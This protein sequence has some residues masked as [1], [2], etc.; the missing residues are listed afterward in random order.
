[1]KKITANS[2]SYAAKKRNR[3]EV[4]YIIIHYTGNTGD[5]AIDNGRFFKRQTDREAG[6]HFFIDREGVIVKSVA[7]NRSAWAVGGKKLNAGGK[8]HGIITNANSVS[9]ELCDNAGKDPSVNQIK[10]VKKCIKY[11]R[12]YCKNA[13]AVYRHYDVTGKYCPIRMIDNNPWKDFLFKIGEA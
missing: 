13:T 4:K 1:M 3:K 10:A 5:T 11:I 6:A 12:K 7:L 2:H 9:I 8:M